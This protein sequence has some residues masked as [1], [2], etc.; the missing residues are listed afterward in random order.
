MRTRATLDDRWR[1]SEDEY[2]VQRIEGA[3]FSKKEIE[4]SK[5]WKAVTEW[6]KERGDMF[7]S[8]WQDNWR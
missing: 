3:D 4:A 7:K 6:Q 5:E 1:F 8:L 2:I